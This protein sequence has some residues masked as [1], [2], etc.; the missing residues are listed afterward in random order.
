LFPLGTPVSTTIKTARHDRTEMLLKVVLNTIKQTNNVSTI[1]T[2]IECVPM[3]IAV[4]H[5]LIEFEG[6]KY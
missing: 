4:T 2:L 1:H 6:I 3:L 5:K